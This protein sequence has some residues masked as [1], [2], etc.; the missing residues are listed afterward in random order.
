M[1]DL[2]A[3]SARSWESGGYKDLMIDWSYGKFS[4]LQR[5]YTSSELAFKAHITISSITSPGNSKS[6]EIINVPLET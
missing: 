5:K 6:Y 1:P 3:Y 4:I 2:N